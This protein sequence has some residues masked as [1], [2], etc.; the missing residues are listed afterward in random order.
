MLNEF[1]SWCLDRFFLSPGSRGPIVRIEVSDTD[2]A[3][4]F[5]L[6]DGTAISSAFRRQLPS[7]VKVAK[8][9]SGIHPAPYDIEPSSQPG[10][11]PLRVPRFVP[12]LVYLCWIQAT[13]YRERGDRDIRLLIEN[14]FGQAITDLTELPKLWK[15]LA[16]YLSRKF[17][18]ELRLPEGGF[19]YVGA[20]VALPFPTWRHLTKLRKLR[21]SI[22]KK[23]AKDRS[24]KEPL[25]ERHAVMS[26]FSTNRE[27]T[28]FCSS[29]YGHGL[30]DAFHE[31]RRSVSING[32]DLQDLAF[33]RAWVR[34][35]GEKRPIA[36]LEFTIDDFGQT[37]FFVV[38]SNES[39]ER[40]SSPMEG[41][42]HFAKWLTSALDKGAVYLAPL[43]F[44]RWAT[45]E[46]CQSRYALFDRRQEKLSRKLTIES[47]QITEGWWLAETELEDP[48][49]EGSTEP[50]FRMR[51][52]IRVGGS[53][54]GMW[55]MA[56][57]FEFSGAVKPTALQ[58]GKI[59]EMYSR[60][61]V[62]FLPET[63]EPG[64]VSIILGETRRSLN[65]VQLAEEHQSD[66]IRHLSEDVAIPEDGDLL[67]TCPAISEA[68]R[69]L[70]AAYNPHRRLIALGEA[71]YT[72]GRRGMTMSDFINLCDRARDDE[73]EPSP[74]D[75]AR[76]FVD[77]GWFEPASNR[78]YPGRLFFLRPLRLRSVSI[79]GTRWHMLDGPT[80]L[81][82]YQRLT[83]CARECGLRTKE[84]GGVGNWSLPKILIEVA[85]HK[86]QHLRECIAIK[87]IELPNVSRTAAA[88][89]STPLSIE[90]RDEPSTWNPGSGYFD[91]RLSSEPV[92]LER[93]EYSQDE[94]APVYAVRT[95]SS[96]E[97]FHSPT[98]ALL[99]YRD[100]GVSRPYETMDSR[101]V[102][103]GERLDYLPAAWGRWLGNVHLRN[104]GPVMTKNGFSYAYPADR[105]SLDL[106]NTLCRLVEEPAGDIVPEWALSRASSRIRGH[107]PVYVDGRLITRRNSYW[108][109]SS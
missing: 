12:L 27:M 97:T 79:E 99:R 56:P 98:L 51:N 1:E 105:Q 102:R 106:V 35:V 37:Q 101:I 26:A 109:A 54:L 80:P 82:T 63:V 22:E 96:V 84:V 40:I 18:I 11:T 83:T 36:N 4:R 94:R 100:L 41:R 29:Q 46:T 77:A 59:H 45:S 10:E 50:N 58:D 23:S 44:G 88:A 9:L 93:H 30:R 103:R 73:V 85:P 53:Y 48:R 24:Q 15:L 68:A 52:A 43:G 60:G 65:L 64:K 69:E 108:T 61:N 34:V 14:H 42:V 91:A 90:D 16:D 8:I 39:R 21:N 33:D 92:R 32:L 78:R 31:W 107:R 20:T 67:D 38:H 86:D 47:N 87:D 3:E 5:G 17:D 74:F 6:E 71:L 81:R 28:D 19:R 25:L 62:A 89:W 13:G 66:Q 7:V 2:L 57:S 104:A 70:G 95:A 49:H 72:R 75:I 55:P 76:A